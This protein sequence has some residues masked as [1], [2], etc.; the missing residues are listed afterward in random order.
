MGGNYDILERRAESWPIKEGRQEGTGNSR[1]LLYT[2]SD[3][4]ACNAGRDAT[5]LRAC[6][7]AKGVFAQS[8]PEIRS[9]RRSLGDI[10][11]LAVC[12]QGPTCTTVA[13]H[14]WDG[15]YLC[16]VTNPYAFVVSPCLAGLARRMGYQE[17]NTRTQRSIRGC[18]KPL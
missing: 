17:R 15:G 14:G 8:S 16:L 18:C 12:H 3:A 10:G 1:R 7:A 13:G 2:V 4:H 6:T 11:S 5:V 9:E